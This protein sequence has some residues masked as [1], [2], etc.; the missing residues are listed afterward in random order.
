[1]Q[2]RELHG[3]VNK[4]PLPRKEGT[5]QSVSPCLVAVSRASDTHRC[6]VFYEKWQ[7]QGRRDKPCTEI[8][9]SPS[10]QMWWRCSGHLSTEVLVYGGV[11]QETAQ[12]WEGTALWWGRGHWEV[13][14]ECPTWSAT[15]CS[16]GSIM[17]EYL[18]IHL[19][20]SATLWSVIA[21]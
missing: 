1:M 15:L 16:L 21:N 20:K 10:L 6:L 7:C 18:Y 19:Y 17:Y 9:D 13:M 11:P 2:R 8:W 4:I 12:G 14:G 5:T 3:G